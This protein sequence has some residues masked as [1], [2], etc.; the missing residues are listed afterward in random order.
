MA[1][2]CRCRKSGT[3]PSAAARQ[4]RCSQPLERSAPWGADDHQRRV[5]L[6]LRFGSASQ[7][8]AYTQR[9]AS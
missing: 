3:P 2:A 9:A 1:G 4:P 7:Q 8:V 5:A 6:G